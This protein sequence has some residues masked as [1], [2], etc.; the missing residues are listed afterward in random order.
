MNKRPSTQFYP[1]DWW[2]AVD[3]RKCCM[4]TQ[5]C[6]FNMLLVMWDEKKQGKISGTKV[7]ICRVVG[8]SLPELRRFLDDNKKHN[9]ANVTFCNKNVT[10]INRRMYEAYIERENTKKRV[11]KHRA[12]SKQEC[13]ANV[14]LPSSTSSSTSSSNKEY[15]SIFDQARKLFRGTKRGNQTEFNNFTKKHKDWEEKLPLLKPAI[16]NQILWREQDNRYWKNFQTW[17]NQSC[18]EEERGAHKETTE[19]MHNR[20]KAEGK[21]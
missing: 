15:M 21:L 17:I 5:G 9:F 7:E 16:E 6:W 8:C 4:S 12:G 2:R 19:E 11:A 1:G 10:I 14:T 20:L 3:L 18:W 13:N